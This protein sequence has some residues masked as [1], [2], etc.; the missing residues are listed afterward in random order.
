MH[1]SEHLVQ[2]KQAFWSSPQ[3][4]WNVSCIA[5]TQ[6]LPTCETSRSAVRD[7]GSRG[8]RQIASSRKTV[9]GIDE[10]GGYPLEVAP[11]PALFGTLRKC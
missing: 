6:L 11:G 8:I 2:Y 7:D 10:R 9:E 4:N 3:R 1:Q 5:K